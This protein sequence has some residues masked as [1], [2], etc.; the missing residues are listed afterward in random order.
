MPE[1]AFPAALPHGSIALIKPRMKFPGEAAPHSWKFVLFVVE[2]ISLV[3]TIVD[4]CQKRVV[5]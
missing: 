4:L 3:W 2:E 5:R 1:T